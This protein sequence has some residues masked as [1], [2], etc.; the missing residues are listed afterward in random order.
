MRRGTQPWFGRAAGLCALLVAVVAVA[1]C[2]G[3][4]RKADANDW[5]A[6][7]CKA[8]NDLREARAN[9]LL[10]FFEVDS[11]DGP[12]MLEGFETYTKTYGEALDTFEKATGQAGQP[13]V[14]DGGK[15]KA[16]LGDWISA[17]R[18]SNETAEEK[19]SK[20]DRSSERLAGEVEDVFAA[21]QFADLRELLRDSRAAGADQ[22][23]SLI[24]RDSLCAFELFAEEE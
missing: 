24:E 20:L 10:Q 1:N 3:G 13:D 8:A 12:A 17:E 23:I 2:G 6:D 9:A 4:A 7:V 11:G 18:R 21:I 14:K 22:I 19:A 16:A 15:V 5:V